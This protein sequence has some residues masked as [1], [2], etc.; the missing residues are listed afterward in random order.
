MAGIC[1]WKEGWDRKDTGM[2]GSEVCYPCEDYTRTRPANRDGKARLALL[3]LG[4]KPKE[5]W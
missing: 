4:G 5:P 3:P 1:P 2:G